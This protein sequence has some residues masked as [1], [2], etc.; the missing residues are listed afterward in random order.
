MSM[1]MASA[2]LICDPN[3]ADNKK[4]APSSRGARDKRMPR[5]IGICSTHDI[6]SMLTFTKYHA[7]DLRIK[8]NLILIMKL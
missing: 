2:Q 5:T 8:V 1:S 6:S 4:P 7:D 3:L